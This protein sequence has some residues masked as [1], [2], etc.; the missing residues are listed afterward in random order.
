MK[1]TSE[2]LNA[3][4]D[5][6][7]R[8]VQSGNDSVFQEVFDIRA[9]V[10]G[11]KLVPILKLDACFRVGIQVGYRLAEANMMNKTFEDIP[12]QRSGE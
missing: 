8:D 2:S 12:V 10:L 4:V 6:I 3:Q 7:D 5:A 9:A 1:I 11:S